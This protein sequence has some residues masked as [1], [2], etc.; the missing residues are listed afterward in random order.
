MENV[1]RNAI[2]LCVAATALAL[3]ARCEAGGFFRRVPEI[4]EWARFEITQVHTS[5]QVHASE[6]D[7]HWEHSEVFLG[8]VVVKCV[9]EEMID[10]RRHLWIELCTEMK[11]APESE[12]SAVT[13]VLVPEDELPL[14]VITNAY[15]R[16]WHSEMKREPVELTSEDSVGDAGDGAVTGRMSSRTIV[17][18]DE[19][20]ELTYLETTPLPTQENENGTFTGEVT[21]WPH[22]DLAFGVASVDVLS[23][24]VG[25][26]DIPHGTLNE[27]RYDLAESGT[28]AVSELPDHN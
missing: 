24:Q 15:V 1:M 27:T 21:I 12:F 28:D 14:G 6:P 26:G 18:G 23:R 16:G 19:E 11:L 13:K 3:S 7:K 8:S 20:I 10:E 17:V 22:A 5:T 2:N 25:V 4:G 9:G